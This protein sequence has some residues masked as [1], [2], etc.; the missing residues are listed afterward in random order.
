M[1]ES[2][3]D[4]RGLALVPGPA[5]I[6]QPLYS[7][8]VYEELVRHS[9]DEVAKTLLAIPG[10]RQSNPAEPAS[11]QWAARWAEGDRYLD[12]DLTVME[13][14][15]GRVVWGGSNLRGRCRV[16]DLLGCWA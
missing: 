13:P 2:L 8:E 7:F 11:G 9:P 14:E 6:E 10:V 15:E 16:S 1:G 12:L 5:A 3:L 4:A